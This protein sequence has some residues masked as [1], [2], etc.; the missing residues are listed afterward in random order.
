[1][2]TL[3]MALILGGVLLP[4][5]SSFNKIISPNE[6]NNITL[7]GRL[8]TDFIN[9][10]RAWKITWKNMKQ[11]NYE[12]VYAIWAA[13]Y[14]TFRYTTFQFNAKGIYCPVK[15]DIMPEHEIKYNGS[16]I[17]NFYII[18]SEQEPIS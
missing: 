1:M 5:Y 13:Q 15:V 11:E 9:T 18:L 8:S 17:A 14:T 12:I 4:Y 7:G 10:R 6:T 3:D 16:L 2:A